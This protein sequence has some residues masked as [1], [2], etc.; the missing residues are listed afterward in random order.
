[1]RASFVNEKFKEESDP[2]KDMGIGRPEKSIFPFLS[3]ELNKYNI[4]ISW[5]KDINLGEGFWFFNIDDTDDSDEL[6]WAYH[7]I[8]EYAT[9]E[10]I[11]NGPKNDI[12]DW[13]SGF[14]LL[15][16]NE[17]SYIFTGVND[18]NIVIKHL[19]KLKFGTKNQVKR[20]IDKAEKHINMLKEVEKRL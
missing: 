9:K 17:D 13:E 7:I 3:K 14:S 5:K 15:N 20:K 1:M 19:L 16:E 12:E 18:L 2:I 6:Y 8:L 11:L 4:K 10:A